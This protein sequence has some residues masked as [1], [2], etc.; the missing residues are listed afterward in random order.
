MSV[1]QII[2]NFLGTVFEIII[3]NLLFSI[4]AKRVIKKNTL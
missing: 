1:E 3:L 4:I 2:I